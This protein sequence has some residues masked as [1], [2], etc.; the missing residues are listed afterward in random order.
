MVEPVYKPVPDDLKKD[1][2]QPTTVNSDYTAS[3]SDYTIFADTT[4]N[5]VTITLPEDPRI[6]KTFRI[7]DSEGNSATNAI[8]ISAAGTTQILD[9]STDP[10]ITDNFGAVELI[11]TGGG[12]YA[13]IGAGLGT[14]SGGLL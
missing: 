9:L 14:G 8:T 4:N 5:T 13:E 11:Y 3:E 10:T 1:L 7:I 12:T 6:G 2:A